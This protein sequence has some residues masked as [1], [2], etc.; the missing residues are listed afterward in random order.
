MMVPVVAL[1]APL[2]AFFNVALATNVVRHRTRG[3]KDAD[4]GLTTAIRVHGNNAEF[5]PLALVLM[6]VCELCGG[7]SFWLHITGGIL[8][9]AR[10]AHALGMP[11][12][13]PNALRSAGVVGTWGVI[14]A[15]GGYA[16]WL[17]SKG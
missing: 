4:K 1:Y 9:A 6:L 11:L 10:V 16:L 5:V 15:L 13:A 12:K 17:R 7:A 8:L 14:V 2:N 3:A